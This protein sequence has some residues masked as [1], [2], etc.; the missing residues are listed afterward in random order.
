MWGRKKYSD[1]VT[2][3][4]M[5]MTPYLP[6]E[7]RRSMEAKDFRHLALYDYQNSLHLYD[8]ETGMPLH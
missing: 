4:L 6:R 2:C 1:H 3:T 5:R 8:K 7:V